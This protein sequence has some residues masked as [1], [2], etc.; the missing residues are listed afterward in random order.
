MITLHWLYTLAG[1]MFAAFAASGEWLGVS[2][3]LPVLFGF[4]VAL[5]RRFSANYRFTVSDTPAVPRAKLD[6]TPPRILTIEPA[7]NVTSVSPSA[8]LSPSRDWRTVASG[9]ASWC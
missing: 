2:A 5:F 1:A 3:T 8:S 9:L 6:A 7:T 4:G